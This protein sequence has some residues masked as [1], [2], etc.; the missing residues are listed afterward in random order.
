MTLEF[1]DWLQRSFRVGGQGG[2]GVGPV[3]GHEAAE[4]AASMPATK[5]AAVS[6]KRVV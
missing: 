4:S 6:I 1:P 5:G 2:P 3:G